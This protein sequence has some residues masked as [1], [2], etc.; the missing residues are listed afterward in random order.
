[1]DTKK[2]AL[3]D[4][5]V[6]LLGNAML[7]S[8]Q[9]RQSSL[10]AQLLDQSKA[11]QVKRDRM[12]CVALQKALYAAG[13]LDDAIS[14]AID[15]SKDELGK[16]ST[17]KARRLNE[18]AGGGG[19]LACVRFKD[20]LFPEGVSGR[21]GIATAMDAVEQNELHEPIAQLWPSDLMSAVRELVIDYAKDKAAL[22]LGLTRAQAAFIGLDGLVLRKSNRELPNWHLWN[23]KPARQIRRDA[24]WLSEMRA[25]FQ[26]H[27][28]QPAERMYGDAAAKHDL[29]DLAIR[30]E[31]LG[32][33]IKDGGIPIHEGLC[34]LGSQLCGEPVVS[35]G[36]IQQLFPSYGALLEHKNYGVD[37][38]PFN[39]FVFMSAQV[40]WRAVKKGWVI[41]IAEDGLEGG[42]FSWVSPDSFPSLS[43]NDE[44]PLPEEINVDGCFDLDER[45]KSALGADRLWFALAS[46]VAAT[47]DVPEQLSPDNPEEPQQTRGYNKGFTASDAPF[48]KEGVGMLE[49]GSAKSALNAAQ[50]LVTK[51]GEITENNWVPG[52]FGIRSYTVGAAEM[53]LQ[54]AISKEWKKLKSIEGVRFNPIEANPDK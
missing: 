41:C 10:H 29:P 36:T 15:L 22:D 12:R 19:K 33:A 24:G 39:V 1:M 54:K 43:E 52:Q 18:V 48:I 38:D 17:N 51:Y 42:C 23:S 14:T 35:E 30:F 7:L 5:G 20:F 34:E 3:N 4:I 40:A 13:M 6:G 49:V 27:V 31:Q 46:D 11:L 45:T 9:L 50:L 47:L 2:I 25:K 21:Y 37:A 32:D 26:R 28:L 53:R 44:L 8:G 16:G